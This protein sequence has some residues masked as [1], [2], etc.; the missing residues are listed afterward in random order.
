MNSLDIG[1]VVPPRD[2]PDVPK[3]APKVM[4]DWLMPAEHIYAALA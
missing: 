1:Q 2:D 4:A 3:P